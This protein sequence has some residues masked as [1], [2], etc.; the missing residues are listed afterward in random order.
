MNV[1]V[2][3]Y[4]YANSGHAIDAGSGSMIV[5]EGNIFQNVVT[6][7]LSPVSGQIFTSPTTSANTVC[8][9]SLGHNCVLNAFGRSGSFSGSDTGFLSNFDGKTVASASSTSGL[10]SSIVANAGIGKI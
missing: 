3:N 5:A 2:N 10:A 8:K 9:N 6:P 7:L 1:K 4:W